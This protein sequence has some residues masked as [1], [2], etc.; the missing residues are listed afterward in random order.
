MSHS[1][2][3][4]PFDNP[5][6]LSKVG[7]WVMTFLSAPEAKWVELAI[8]SVLPRQNQNILQPRRLVIQQTAE[9]GVWTIKTLECYDQSIKSD[10]PVALDDTQAMAVFQQIIAEFEKYDV[11]I[12]LLCTENA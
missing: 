1:L 7:N 9:E 10:V 12:Q 2:V 3:F 6:H 11:E 4:A 5:M 8:T